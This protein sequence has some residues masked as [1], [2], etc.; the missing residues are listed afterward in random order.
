MQQ[1][2]KGQSGG[3]DLHQL[4]HFSRLSKLQSRLVRLPVSR[5]TEEAAEAE[6]MLSQ[7]GYTFL[8]FMVG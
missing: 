8:N 5:D 3:L 1:R 7:H 2:R 6:T 4:M